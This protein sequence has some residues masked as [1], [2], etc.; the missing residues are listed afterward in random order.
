VRDEKIHLISSLG[1]S[2]PPIHPLK[3]PK[4]FSNNPKYYL[5]NKHA[6]ILRIFKVIFKR[7]RR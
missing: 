4:D 5:N 6:R 1:V 7:R 3:M 2:S